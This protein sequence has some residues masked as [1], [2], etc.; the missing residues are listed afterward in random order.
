MS[1]DYYDAPIAWD[2]HLKWTCFSMHPMSSVSSERKVY[3]LSCFLFNME[4]F[5]EIYSLLDILFIQEGTIEFLPY[6]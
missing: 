3:D 6:T 5:F 2:K 4:L 1:T